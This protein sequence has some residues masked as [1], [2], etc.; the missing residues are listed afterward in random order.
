MHPNLESALGSLNQK[1]CTRASVL[2]LL[3]G[4]ELLLSCCCSAAQS[5]PPGSRRVRPSAACAP[6]GVHTGL[7]VAK[8]RS[9]S[10]GTG[11]EDSEQQA[12]G[13]GT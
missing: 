12:A 10:T 9:C 3:A 4:M 6:S 2:N 11:L 5:A 8:G 7:Q 1:S 13:D